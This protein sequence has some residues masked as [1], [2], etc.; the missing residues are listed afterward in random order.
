MKLDRKIRKLLKNFFWEKFNPNWL[1]ILSI[2]GLLGG[3]IWCIFTLFDLAHGPYWSVSLKLIILN[4]L[5]FTGK[6]CIGLYIF[7]E[8]LRRLFYNYWIKAAVPIIYEEE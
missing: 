2:I 1:K 6:L 7:F 4:G 3:S 8:S 5:Y